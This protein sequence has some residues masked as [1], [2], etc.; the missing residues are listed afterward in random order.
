MVINQKKLERQLG[1]VDKWIKETGAKG[2]FEGCTGFGKTFTAVLAIKRFRKKYAQEPIIVVVPSVDL[3]FQWEQVLER[4][5]IEFV[6][7]WVV[8]TYIK[9]KHQASL[10]ILDEVHRFLSDE[11]YKLFE[12][13]HYQLLLCLTATLERLD[14][15]HDLLD[16]IAPVF[17]VVTMEEAKREGYVSDFTV[18]N[19][20]LEFNEEDQEEYKKYHDIANNNFAYFHRDFDLAM[21]MARSGRAVVTT[22]DERRIAH[23]KT[24]EELRHEWAKSQGWDGQPFVENATDTATNYYHPKTVMLKALQWLKGVRGRKTLIYKASAKLNVIEEL[25]WKFP[26]KKVIIFSEDAD[27]ADKVKERLGDECRS[28]HTKLATEVRK[29]RTEKILKSGEVKVTYTEKKF[30]LTR[31]RK[32][33]IE[34]FKNNKFKILSVVRA[35]DEGFDDEDVDMII[36]ASYNSSKR[37]NVQ[38]T[39]RGI[40]AKEGKHAIVI[41]LY[42][43]NSQ[44]ENWLKSKQQ[45]TSNILWAKSIADIRDVSSFSLT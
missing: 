7:V 41:N 8:N 43:K 44:E 30:G 23:R 18:Y 40:R 39:G 34:D 33:I 11:F 31:L 29:I 36:M 15:K 16:E 24:V 4:E 26:D 2:T 32:E 35:L 42:M 17:D 38:R 14:G 10:L 1:I 45:S 27:F 3:K 13:T 20:G 9:Y 19:L 28:Y 22:Y 37:Q 6:S 21:M 25:I 5:S 12:N